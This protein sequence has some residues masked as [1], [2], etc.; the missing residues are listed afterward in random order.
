MQTKVHGKATRRYN[1]SE[2]KRRE[3]ERGS[4]MADGELSPSRIGALVRLLADDNEKIRRIARDNLIACIAAGCRALSI[5]EETARGTEDPQV[6]VAARRFLKFAQREE[7]L[8]GW[9]AFAAGS[10]LDLATGACR[11]AHAGAHD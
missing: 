10:E 8:S 1:V 11:L 6:R 7:A 4:P 5:V 3:I 9:I 2:K